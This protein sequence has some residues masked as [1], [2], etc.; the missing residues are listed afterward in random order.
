MH[1]WLVL[2]RGKPG[3]LYYRRGDIVLR[4]LPAKQQGVRWRRGSSMCPG[5]CPVNTCSTCCCTCCTCYYTRK[6]VRRRDVRM[7]KW[8]IKNIC[9]T[10]S[11][12]LRRTIYAS[13]N[14]AS[15]SL[16]L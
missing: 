3:S 15:A 13:G 7:H 4:G 9:S 14:Y 10:K 12:C 2:G 8:T 1:K 16:H 6:H 5:T 11:I